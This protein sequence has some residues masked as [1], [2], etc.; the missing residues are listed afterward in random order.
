MTPSSS[1]SSRSSNSN[2]D[3]NSSSSGSSWGSFGNS[4]SVSKPNFSKNS[5]P[6]EAWM[7]ETSGTGNSMTRAH[8]EEAK[9]E[10]V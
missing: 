5:A 4:R 6:V 7:G 9:E 3:A 1:S 10:D 8:N 2:H